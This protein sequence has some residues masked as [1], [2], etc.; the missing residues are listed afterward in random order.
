MRNSKGQIVGGVEYPGD[1]LTGQG[2]IS[3][4]NVA[5]IHPEWQVDFHLGYDF[6][7]QDYTDVNYICNL[8][9]LSLPAEY[10]EYAAALYEG[11]QPGSWRLP[12]RFSVRV[13][14]SPADYLAFTNILDKNSLENMTSELQALILE[15]LG[16]AKNQ[17]ILT[18]KIIMMPVCARVCCFLRI[19]KPSER[20]NWFSP[21]REFRGAGSSKVG[22][23]P[24]FLG[25]AS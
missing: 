3:G 20:V 14:Q 12:K 24:D 10:R 15:L 19:N 16:G 21:W 2:R 22:Y 9:K 6:D 18:W 8:F 4:M 17:K 5:C 25:E 1:S 7:H 11:N 13:P 23:P